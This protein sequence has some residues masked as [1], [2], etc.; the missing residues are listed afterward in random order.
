[1]TNDLDESIAIVGMAARVPG[2]HDTEEFWRNL[3]AGHAA[4]RFPSDDELLAVGVPAA[5][6][7]DPDYV[8]AVM[9]APGLDMF[10]AGFFG[11]TPRDAA[12]LD[13]QIRL[14][15][16]LAH[17]AIED[18]GYDPHRMQGV[19]V[20]G[21]A[22]TNRYLELHARPGD[23][24]ASSAGELA[25][26]A[27]SYPDY[28][29]AHVSYRFGFRGPAMTVST[30]CS[31]SAV[32]V[33]LASQALRAGECDFAVA[34]GSELE[35]PLHHGYRWDLGGPMSSDGH[36][37]PFDR[38][39]DG[40][41]FSSGG[42]AVLLRRLGD[43]IA[44]D[45]RILAVI[46]ASACGNDGS[47]K[48]GFS[49]PGVAG[50]V[51]VVT[52]A[53]RMADVR[54]PDVSFVEAHA[55]G[56]ALGD[57]IEVAA[58]AQAYAA[59][60]GG[61]RTEPVVVSSVKGN[62]GHLGHASGVAS[63]VKLVLCLRQETLVPTVGFTEPNPRCKFPQTPFE[64]ADRAI[65]WPR[66]PGVPRIAGLSS[67]GIG[68]TGV[69]LI[70]EEPP[71]RSVAPV[72]V[73]GPQIVVWSARTPSAADAYGDRLRE[74]L[75]QADDSEFLATVTTLQDGRTP[76]AV[77]RAIVATGPREAVEAMESGKARAGE[78]GGAR[79]VVFAFPGQSAQHQAMAA[80]LYGADPV[81]TRTMDECLD[82]LREYGLDL[83]EVWLGGSD[84]DL[85]D[86][87]VAQPLLFAVEYSLAEMWKSWDIRPSTVIGHSLGEVTAGAVAGI[88]E[89]PDA[90]RLVHAR[91]SAMSGMQEGGMVA[92]AAQPD[93]LSAH[94]P[95]GVTIAVVNDRRQTVISGTI[96]GIG[97]ARDALTA[98]GFK[99]TPLSTSHA[100]H[101]PL[102]ARAADKFAVAL[103]DV[104][105]REPVLPLV[106]AAAGGLAGAEVTQPGFWADQLT[107]PVW[108]ARALDSLFAEGPKTVVEV[109]PGHTLTQL[110]KARSEVRQG[111]GSAVPTL[112]ARA[113]QDDRAAA[114]AAAA[115]LWTQGYEVE[116]AAVRR[117]K[118]VRRVAVPGYPY[119]RERHWLPMRA[120]AEPVPAQTA[121]A[122]VEP[123][124]PVAP[125]TRLTWVEQSGGLGGGYAS[126]AVALVIA[127]SDDAAD[128]ALLALGQAGY[129]PV[130]FRPGTEFIEA[131]GEFR[132][133]ADRVADLD[134]AFEA[135]AGRG[136]RPALLVH[137]LSLPASGPLTSAS[138]TARAVETFH[139]YTALA[140]SGARHA[141][142][143]GLLVLTS[144]SADITGTEPLDP[145]KATLHG[146]VRSLAREIPDIPCR[147]I[148]VGAATDIP[149]LAAEVMAGGADPVV[150]LRGIAR[151]IPAERPYEPG[152]A[153]SPVIRQGGVYV[154]TGGLGGLGLAVAKALAATGMRP[155]LVLLSRSAVS[156]ADRAAAQLAE[157]DR[158]G[159]V[160]DVVTCD[161][162]NRRDLRRAID[163]VRARHGEI[164]GV[165]HLAGVPGDG[166]L[167][168]RAR[169]DSDAVLAP[170]LA[171]STALAEVL[172]GRQRLDFYV[173]FS[174]RAAV[175]GLVGG[176]DY[177]A[178]NAFLDAHT[179]TVS[180]L[181]TKALSINW[182]AWHSVGMAAQPEQHIRGARHWET[183]VAVQSE[184]VLD[185]HRLG[186][187]PVL[188]G[189]GHLDM[190]VRAY[191]EV[192]G[193][194]APLRLRDVVFLRVL[195]AEA[196]RVARVEFRPD[197]ADWAFTVSSV[198]ADGS[199][200]RAEHAT[201]TVGESAV[202]PTGVTALATLRTRLSG[203]APPRPPAPGDPRLFTI[204]PRW[205]T[206]R[207]ISAAAA[208]DD[209]VRHADERL[210]DLV[211]PSQF[212]GDLLTH[213]L[214]PALLDCATAEA[215]VDGR[216]DPH[217]P[218]GYESVEIHQDL[219][220]QIVSHIRRRP[221]GAGL[222]VAD[223]DIFAPDGTLVVRIVG[224][225]MR[226]VESAG[227]ITETARTG[228]TA[229]RDGIDPVVGARL[230]LTLLGSER[231]PHQLAVRPYLDGKPI[232][233]QHV[234]AV[235]VPE[236]PIPE[237]V[238]AV[239]ATPVAQEAPA[240]GTEAL[241][242]R[243]GVLWRSVLG[244]QT[245]GDLDDFFE[246]G[247]NSLAAVELMSGIRDEFGV[248]LSLVTMFD[249]PTFGALANALAQAKR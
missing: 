221:G 149:A 128:N 95:D 151:W 126:G 166:M 246:L 102:M 231:H 130:V 4:V 56:T 84:G 129:Q 215:R 44:D 72:T 241:R 57:P 220:A 243:L 118:P 82:G 39:A 205:D 139:S 239:A 212:H 35:M 88:F 140:Q 117:H 3:A 111:T 160:V 22:G 33:H 127:P 64:V 9:S 19:G 199:G 120:A 234:P 121:P 103:A 203:S 123:A 178:A 107:A 184:P 124:E 171:G 26:S 134:A 185:E 116:W 148:D 110:T 173:A 145:V 23:Q 180:S 176:A 225:T 165:L 169:Q 150:A 154:L 17:N 155:R 31:S 13:P 68:G 83:R 61:L 195:A 238:R 138:V 16:E 213:P 8:R 157:L 63:L 51:S 207:R 143:A 163:T 50:Q 27:L 201:G 204:G 66:T 194:A 43:A 188:P 152:V 81:F 41:V 71:V 135:L 179:R 230:L 181:A 153:G 211:L 146:A 174:S 21:S 62:I 193:S 164:H 142:T 219:P 40:T 133:Q 99:C 156:R 242:S 91:A 209:E 210:V 11:F 167:L 114:L 6:L 60:G 232:S 245:V 47:A 14:F 249:H 235:V 2:A 30:A 90:L 105:L 172:A 141:P 208:T 38:A 112:P 53:M 136:V 233:P 196:P 7:T 224:Y 25:L 12:A 80:G 237:P 34:G 75:G 15:L 200:S 98:L 168:R 132:G 227:A 125:F 24:Y 96:D 49:A 177:A 87:L 162:T 161:L 97:K 158:L 202:Q 122:Q 77:R 236:R 222:I 206:V 78:V 182:P 20:F 74:H 106:S 226:R 108:F 175:G 183:T 115:D 109:G 100:F 147:L 229:P 244:V 67:F 76:H 119:E 217:L 247:G 86:T 89:L 85:T 5:A 214:H 70:V 29:A 18:A 65:P 59:L 101:S 170:K 144:R 137:A 69:H 55:T 36:C 48:A 10:D 159:A 218:F 94:L 131:D 189:T 46:R 190:V 223:V 37:R 198:S 191:R 58:L 93:E 52:E 79:P 197:G 28:V 104:R 45:D 32:A 240:S 92:V 73:D 228:T 113:G 42:G 248:R 216:D 187:V 186:S 192:F 1:M 54:A